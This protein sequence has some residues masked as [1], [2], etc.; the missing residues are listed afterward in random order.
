MIQ[1]F[2]R[3]DSVYEAVRF[4]LHELDPQ[5]R[6]SIRSLDEEADRE[7]SG[8]ELLQDGLLV[9]AAK[10]PCALVFIYKRLP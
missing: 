8:R 3:Q 10:Q 6:Y 4:R 2:R 9:T 5:A 7:V 1:V